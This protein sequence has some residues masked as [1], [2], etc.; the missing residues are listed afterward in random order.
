MIRLILTFTIFSIA[1]VMFGQNPTVA[2]MPFENLNNDVN[3]DWLSLGISETINSSMAK[4]PSY[5]PIERQKLHQII[6][7]QKLSMTGILDESKAVEVGRLAGAEILIV[8]SYQKYGTSIRLS[9]RLVNVESGVIQKSASA[10]G[11]MTNIFDIQD[12]LV[13]KLLFSEGNE[14]VKAIKIL[15]KH[16]TSLDA[17]ENFGNGLILES[18]RDINGAVKLYAKALEKDNRF[19]I[20]REK[21]KSAYWSIKEGNFWQYRMTM[22]LFVNG[23][24]QKQNESIVNFVRIPGRVTKFNDVDAF[25]FK[26]K[27]GTDKSN[28]NESIHVKSEHG[29]MTIGSIDQNGKILTYDPPYLAYP[30]EPEIGK[31]YNYRYKVVDEDNNDVG[32]I[33]ITMTFMD[34]E[35]VLLKETE[36]QAFKIKT[37]LNVLSS[38]ASKKSSAKLTVMQIKGTSW[39]VPG[40]GITR[41]MMNIK[42][43]KADFD[44]ELVVEK[45]I[46]DFHIR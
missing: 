12:Q 28:Q 45:K 18:K 36:Y 19:A 27:S 11:E 15:S 37:I 33:D 10:T 14:S 40:I 22:K 41:E 23:L 42:M 9:G 44:L 16:S 17:Y 39:F 38:S 2:V 1:V 35:D 25:T 46:I 32:E 29:I 43:I 26:I 31:T 34:V 6:E 13:A 24:E 5:Q 21:Y 20:A 3:L 8:G 4:L 30:Y 7:E